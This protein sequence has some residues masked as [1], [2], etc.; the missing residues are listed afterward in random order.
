M[1]TTAW[2]A[3]DVSPAVPSRVSSPE[4]PPGQAGFPLP[5]TALPAREERRDETFWKVPWRLLGLRDAPER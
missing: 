2:P 3:P 5:L 4:L 1:L